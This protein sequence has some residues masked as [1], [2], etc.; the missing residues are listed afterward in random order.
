MRKRTYVPSKDLSFRSSITYYLA[1]DTI[2]NS[3]YRYSKQ[4]YEVQILR[5]TVEGSRLSTFGI[6]ADVKICS[7]GRFS[8]YYYLLTHLYRIGLVNSDFN[9]ICHN[10]RIDGLDRQRCTFKTTVVTPLFGG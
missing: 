5:Q 3:V 7:C 9:P 4:L 10:S 1:R 6:M 2:E 8:G